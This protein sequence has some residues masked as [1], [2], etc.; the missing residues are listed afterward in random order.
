[1][2]K[3]QII[4]NMTCYNITKVKY[5]KTQRVSYSERVREV[6]HNIIA[7]MYVIPHNINEYMIFIN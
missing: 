7:I 3:R 2:K 1:M 4:D 5:V 6:C